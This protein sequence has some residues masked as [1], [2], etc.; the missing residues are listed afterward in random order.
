MSQ[1][2]ASSE[3]PDGKGTDQDSSAKKVWHLK[4]VDRKCLKVTLG[5]KGTIFKL[6][7]K[8]REKIFFVKTG[9]K[10]MLRTNWAKDIKHKIF[11]VMSRPGWEPFFQQ[12]NMKQSFSGIKTFVDQKVRAKKLNFQQVYKILCSDFSVNKYNTYKIST[13]PRN[14][15][16]KIFWEWNQPPVLSSVCPVCPVSAVLSKSPLSPSFFAA[17]NILLIRIVTIKLK[18]LLLFGGA[19][20]GLATWFCLA[21][22]ALIVLQEVAMKIFNEQH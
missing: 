22:D 16:C 19:S 10:T 1:N 17:K 8:C 12:S 11:F 14:V 5:S 18:N 9:I 6:S 13:R 4:N 21:H 3:P 15:T 2:S 20:V 7:K